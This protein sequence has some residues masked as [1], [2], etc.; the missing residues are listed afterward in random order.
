M[1]KY[2]LNIDIMP[3]LLAVGVMLTTETAYRHWRTIEKEIEQL[4]LGNTRQFKL[5][6]A[7]RFEFGLALSI[8]E[9]F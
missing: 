2:L 5:D 9:V 6:V 8:S 4:K 7:R 3:T 1:P